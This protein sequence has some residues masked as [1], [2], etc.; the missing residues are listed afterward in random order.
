[1]RKISIF[2]LAIFTLLFCT[3]KVN[4][5]ATPVPTA[6]PTVTPTYCTDGVIAPTVFNIKSSQANAYQ[7]TMT[8]DDFVQE[9]ERTAQC[10]VTPDQRTRLIN[11]FRNDH[12]PTVTPG[13]A[14]TPTPPTSGQSSLCGTLNNK[15]CND[16]PNLNGDSSLASDNFFCIDLLL[17]RFCLS[18]IVNGVSDLVSNTIGLQDLKKIGSCKQY[19]VDANGN[20]VPNAQN[21]GNA[22]LIDNG[23]PYTLVPQHDDNGECTCQ[24]ADGIQSLNTEYCARYIGSSMG[25]QKAT[26]GKDTKVT[27]NEITKNP[28]YNHCVDCFTLGG[29]WTALGCIYSSNWTVFIQQNVLGLATGL[30]GLAAFM[31]I[32][33][34]AFVLQTSGG[35]AEKIKN[36]QQLLTSCIMGLMLIIFSVFILRLIGVTILHIP[37]LQ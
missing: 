31:C 15:C 24:R 7:N 23:V 26:E 9:V 25:V 18:S 37:G 2:V 1:M 12:A 27:V 20:P 21:N 22:P 36:A 33:Y 19:Q 34:A 16:E 14:P 10:P 30:G 17:T 32:L 13:G 35:N 6:A 5:Q 4:A 8:E 11:E 3:A 29:N 28:E